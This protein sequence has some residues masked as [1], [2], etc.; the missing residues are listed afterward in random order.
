MMSSKE[1]WMIPED[2][3]DD[4]EKVYH[5]YRNKLIP[6]V[7]KTIDGTIKRYHAKKP[8]PMS[9]PQKVGYLY[10]GADFSR[11][12]KTDLDGKD[13]TTILGY[14]T[15]GGYYG[16]FR[17]DIIE[18]MWLL[19]KRFSGEEFGDCSNSPLDNY[20]KIY[21]TTTPFPTGDI[22]DCYDSKKD[23]HRGITRVYFV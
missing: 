1:I 10:C 22:N 9:N 14:H 4:I 18:V 8:L 3:L 17:P 5:R 19:L 20:S 15:Y 11:E 16:F 13:H 6:F 23:R 2:E 12:L 7:E 21:I